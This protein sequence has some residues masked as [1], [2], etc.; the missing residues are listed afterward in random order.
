YGNIEDIVLDV[1]VA[2]A[3][4]RLARSG[5]N[6]RESVG[7]ADPRRW[8]FGSEGCLGIV[9]SAIVKLAPLPESEVYGSIVFRAFDTRLCVLFSLAAGRA[10]ERAARHHPPVPA[11]ADAEA[12]RGGLEADREPHPASRRHEGE[13]LRGR[14]HGGLHDR[15]RGVEGGGARTAEAHLRA[16]AQARRAR[17]G[18]G[19]Q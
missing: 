17:P 4:G 19:R 10:G 6:P 18:R 1:T 8:L 2:T 14:P 15:L 7:S 5:A 16:R 13:G 3:R 11:L 9:T 12:A